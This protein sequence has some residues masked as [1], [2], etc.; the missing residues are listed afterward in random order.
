MRLLSLRSMH[1]SRRA[2]RASSWDPKRISD[3]RSGREAARAARQARRARSQDA[4][5][6]KRNPA[7]FSDAAASRHR[8]TH[9][10]AFADELRRES[11]SAAALA[12]RTAQNQ[13]IAAILHN[14][15]GIARSVGARHLRDR[16]KPQYAAPVEFA[17]T[18]ERILEPV[19]LSQGI[20]FVDD[21]PEPPAASSSRRR[22]M[23]SKMARRIHA[24]NASSARPRFGRPCRE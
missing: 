19:D 23:V 15:V 4:A 11:R 7:D 2:A 22:S 13:R 10:F 12:G 9:D 21:E 24:G 1:A 20:E 5:T 17:Q 8:G 14:R 18:R 6:G 3:S 16:L